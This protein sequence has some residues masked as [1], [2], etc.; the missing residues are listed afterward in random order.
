MTQKLSPHTLS[1]M[2]QV[3]VRLTQFHQQLIPYQLLFRVWRI[4][5]ARSPLKDDYVC[6]NVEIPIGTVQQHKQLQLCKITKH[7]LPVALDKK[8]FLLLRVECYNRYNTNCHCMS[9]QLQ[10]LKMS[11]IKP[12]QV[13][14]LAC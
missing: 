1:G 8:A 2:T 5:V 12:Q 3:L 4:H 10:I 6:W 7:I 9:E 13:A 11:K 14:I